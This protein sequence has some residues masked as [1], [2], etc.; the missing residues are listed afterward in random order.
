MTLLELPPRYL[1]IDIPGR[2]YYFTLN[3]SEICVP[4]PLLFI[5]LSLQQ[6][7]NPGS[8]GKLAVF[9]LDYQKPHQVTNTESGPIKGGEKESS[10]AAPRG[11]LT[12]TT[13][14]KNEIKNKRFS[15]EFTPFCKFRTPRTTAGKRVPGFFFVILYLFFHLGRDIFPVCGTSAVSTC[16]GTCQPLLL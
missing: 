5:S 8:T 12:V 13:R 4:E 14:Q 3:T 10:C 2:K 6:D 11:P 15:L 1:T 9:C 16:A 7:S